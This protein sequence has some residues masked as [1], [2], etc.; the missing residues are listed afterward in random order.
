MISK[1]RNKYDRVIVFSGGGTRFAIYCGMFAAMEDLG[2]APDLIIGA[3]GGSI[4]TTIIS[5]FKTNA[6][7]KKYLQSKELYQFIRNADLTKE[8]MLHHIG[9]YC[10]QKMYSKANAP[11]IENVFDRYLMD[12]PQDLTCQLPSLSSK[13]GS[14]IA[15]I[16]IGSKIL[17][18]PSK[19]DTARNGK[20]LYQKVLFTDELT[21]QKI[22][23]DAI[24]IQSADYRSGAIETSIDMMTNVPMLTAMRI[25]ISDMFYLKP[26]F[27]QDC[28]FAGGAIDLT[29]IELSK[30]LATEVFFEKKSPYTKV[31][32]S[33]VR[34][35]L[36]YSGN[37]RL[38]EI[39]NSGV[40]HWIN[41][42]DATRVLKGHYCKKK[43]N[44]AKFQVNMTLPDSY[45]QFIEDMEMQWNY[46]YEKVK[47]SLSLIRLIHAKA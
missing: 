8:K 43:I 33:I 5:S 6:E 44:W 16:I 1:Q 24:E 29:P 18:H 32:E 35:V 2:I 21:A 22:N 14:T 9:W 10:L 19:T 15:S 23:C 20:K 28:Y 38:Q 47:L 25:S 7:R 46:G 17:F 27:Y 12:I 34:A 13:F 31:E 45:P 11:F 42:A 37:K 4:A 39:D 40:D 41:T 3:C 36:G 26:V 30:H